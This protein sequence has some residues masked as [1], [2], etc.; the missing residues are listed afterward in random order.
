MRTGTAARATAYLSLIHIL[1][2]W[3][4]SG[5]SG[6]AE[7]KAKLLNALGLPPRLSKKELVEALNR[8]YT[9]EQLDEMC[10]RDS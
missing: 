7:R 3:G 8:L 4:L 1:Y 6:S 5:K 2:E 9:F 10:I